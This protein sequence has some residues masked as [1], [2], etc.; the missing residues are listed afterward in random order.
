MKYHNVPLAQSVISTSVVQFLKHNAGTKEKENM[1]FR[2]LF[3]L[4]MGLFEV[5][6]SPLEDWWDLLLQQQQDAGFW[7]YLPSYVVFGFFVFFFPSALPSCHGIVKSFFS[8]FAQ[9]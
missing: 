4:R 8:P 1:H 6:A 3:L 7:F 9:V 5:A 2:S